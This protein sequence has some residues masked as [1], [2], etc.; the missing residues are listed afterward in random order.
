MLTTCSLRARVALLMAA[1]GALTA[2]AVGSVGYR[3]TQSRYTNEIRDSLGRFGDALQSRPALITRTCTDNPARRFAGDGP[4]ERPPTS[5]TAGRSARRNGGSLGRLEP[6][7]A[8]VQCL[9]KSG[10]VSLQSRPF[11]L[12][13]NAEDIK[14]AKAD[15]SQRQARTVDV[16]DRTYRLLSIGL[17]SGGT[18]QVAREITEN[19]RILA[20]LFRSLAWLVV[21]ASVLAGLA[22]LFV[23]S[24]IARPI[25]ALTRTAETIADSGQLDVALPTSR[26]DSETGRLSKA[27]GSMVDALRTS[28]AQQTQLVHDASH[29]LRTPLTS[30]RANIALLR[31]HPDLPA[32][33]RA[34]I[35]GD[36]HDELGELSDLMNELVS[37]ASDETFEEPSARYDAGDVVRDVVARWRRRSGRAIET[38]LPEGSVPVVGHAKVLARSINNLLSNAVKFTSPDQPV[39]VR[40]S[41]DGTTFMTTVDDRGKGFSENDRAHVFDRFYRSEE[42]RS[43]PGS[44][45][46]LAIV[47]KLVSDDGG[48][49]E[50]SNNEF[51]GARVVISLPLK[52][53]PNP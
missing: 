38:E 23:A 36:L 19:D 48:R 52:P 21:A 9:N 40:L 53:A 13:V 6:N 17:S 15:T 37:L 43:L 44:G 27:F 32:D 2:L 22:G 33:R 51:G 25:A 26:S 1:L 5:A 7:G 28:R 14:L 4:I 29:E 50:A 46:G 31:K 49:V 8:I 30:L 47:A 45:L 35:V 20:S 10:V 3:L 12:P 18:V 34:S 42:H 16:N 11:A 24:R 39:Y 41:T